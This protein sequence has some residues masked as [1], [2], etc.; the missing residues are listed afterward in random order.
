MIISNNLLEA[1]GYEMDSR[2]GAL[3]SCHR[4]RWF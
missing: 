1:I 3:L 4:A 2:S